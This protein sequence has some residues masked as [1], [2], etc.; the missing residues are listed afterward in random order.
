LPEALGPLAQYA[1]PECLGA[2]A[3]PSVSTDAAFVVLQALVSRMEEMAVGPYRVEHD[4]SKNLL[5]YHDLLQRYICHDQ[6]VE[7][8]ESEIA[9]IKFPLKLAS[10]T[11]VDSKTS[12]AVQ[13]AD[14]M[15]GAAIDAA[16]T[17]TGQRIGGLDANAVL[18]LYAD[19]QFIHMMPSIDFAEQRRFRQGSQAAELIDYFAAHFH[20]RPKS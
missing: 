15:I 7:F 1:A 5:T 9:R 11:Q 3:T 13:L 6:N 17:L 4:Q 8:R 20:G 14:V 10:V 18:G 12:P 16:N 19:H 2:I